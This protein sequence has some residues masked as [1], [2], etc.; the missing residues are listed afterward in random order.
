MAISLDF[1]DTGKLY[2]VTSQYVSKEIPGSGRG[3]KKDLA[4]TRVMSLWTQDEMEDWIGQPIY[5]AGPDSLSWVLGPHLLIDGGRLIVAFNEKAEQ[6]VFEYDF[7]IISSNDGGVTWTEDVRIPRENNDYISAEMH[8]DANGVIYFP[9][10]TLIGGIETTVLNIT[11]SWFFNWL[12]LSLPGFGS[13]RSMTSNADGLSASF[14]PG[15]N[16][17]NVA[18]IE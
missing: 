7:V 10:R 14:I 16:N 13:I 12:S 11:D 3:Q 17:C 6:H 1:D 9:G 2:V 5:G 8:H 15:E 4:L 18:F